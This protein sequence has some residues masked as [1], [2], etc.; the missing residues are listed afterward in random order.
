MLLKSFCKISYSKISFCRITLCRIVPVTIFAALLALFACGSAAAGT[1]TVNVNGG[2]DFGSIQEAVSSAADGDTILVMSG[3]YRENV[4]VDRQLTI[5]SESGSPADTIVEAA[6]VRDHVFY[7]NADDVRI[8]GFT[9]RGAR[10]EDDQLAGIYLDG[11]GGCTVSSNVLSDNYYG[12]GLK[13]SR[14]NFLLD[15]D[16]SGNRYGIYLCISSSENEMRGNKVSGNY[17]GIYLNNACNNNILTDNTVDSS[18]QDGISLISS[19]KTTV[20]NNTITSNLKI[21]LQADDSRANQIRNNVVSENAKGIFILR[22][23]EN[24][25]KENSIESNS[26]S[27]IHLSWRAPNNTIEQNRLEDNGEGILLADFARYNRVSD[28]LLRANK[29]GMYLLGHSDYNEISGNI[30]LFNSYG[31]YLE[32]CKENVFRENILADN[33]ECGILLLESFDNLIYNNYFENTNNVDEDKP[34]IWNTTLTPGSNIVGGSYLGGN[35][36]VV[37]DRDGFSQTCEDLD[38]DGICDSAYQ[39]EGADYDGDAGADADVDELPLVYSP[40]VNS[41]MQ[42]KA[43]MSESIEEENEQTGAN[44]EK[45]EAEKAPLGVVYSVGIL[46]IAFLIS[47][48]MRNE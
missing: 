23:S 31:F 21:G 33:S 8:N 4:D 32:D 18:R 41:L 9:L 13:N 12:I 5:I 26:G 15:N 29:K 20:R 40:P 46:L 24:Q 22:S 27:G 37:P 48:R 30:L 14:K 36:W 7:V 19:H 39:I 35:C 38:G 6:N 44:V 47:S 45:E 16:A 17:F 2:A 43:I 1:L 28:N 34:N 3:T 11:A 25:V 42:N 10:N